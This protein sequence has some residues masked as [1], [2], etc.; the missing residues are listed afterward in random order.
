MI[1]INDKKYI[2]TY[3][4]GFILLATFLFSCN[5]HNHPKAQIILSILTVIG[6]IICIRY[7]IKNKDALFIKCCTS[8]EII[9]LFI[10][11]K[12]FLISNFT[13]NINLKFYNY[14]SNEL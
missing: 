14:G 12:C 11:Y 8:I 2:R 5:T 13:E 7:S 3:L 9:V 1:Q 6:G 10:F 4:I